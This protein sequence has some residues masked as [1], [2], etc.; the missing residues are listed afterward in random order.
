[1]PELGAETG[2]DLRVRETVGASATPRT[3][4]MHRYLDQVLLLATRRRSTARTFLQVLS[5]IKPPPALF[6]PGILVPALVGMA[7]GRTASPDPSQHG[8][9]DAPGQH[10]EPERV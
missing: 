3:R 10:P 7:T 6:R 2:E 8:A 5:M 1:M 4:F 9:S